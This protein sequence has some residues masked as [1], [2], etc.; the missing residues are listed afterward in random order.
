MVAIPVIFSLVMLLIH[1]HIHVVL[2]G[3][4]FWGKIMILKQ[5][6]II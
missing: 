3:T 1:P 2:W 4:L 6:V 5:L